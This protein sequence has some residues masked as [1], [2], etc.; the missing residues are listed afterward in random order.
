[1]SVGTM[2]AAIHEAIIDPITIKI[3]I[4]WSASRTAWSIPFS[5]RLK[6]YPHRS[7]TSAATIT[8]T[9]R[10]MCG[11][12]SRKKIPVTSATIIKSTGII[13]FSNVGRRPSSGIGGWSGSIF[14]GGGVVISMNQAVL[15]A[16]NIK[17]G[18]EGV[19][20]RYT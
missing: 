7:A 13:A 12:V 2:P 9:S 3:N 20:L 4:A 6:V 17:V 5:I 11:L 18:S 8:L 10:G 19:R 16:E 1:M 14:F 15:L